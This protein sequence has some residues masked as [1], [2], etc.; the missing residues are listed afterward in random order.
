ME[1]EKRT[2]IK[3]SNWEEDPESTL[4]DYYDGH[5]NFAYIGTIINN[6]RSEGLEVNETTEGVRITNPEYIEFSEIPRYYLLIGRKQNCDYDDSI[7]E[8]YSIVR[9]EISS[10]FILEYP[11]YAY[12]GLYGLYEGRQIVEVFE[13]QEGSKKVVESLEKA[14][15]NCF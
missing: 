1:K 10:K 12:I 14:I 4:E 6:L 7:K 8:N 5:W 3:S 13:E 11:C 15:K 9:K 2:E